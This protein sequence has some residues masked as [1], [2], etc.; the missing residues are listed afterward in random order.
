MRWNIE[1]Y[2]KLVKSNFDFQHVTG[3][4]EIE[5]K[6]QMLCINMICS[7]C[8]IM[9]TFM[10]EEKRKLN[11]DCLDE[12]II[13]TNETKIIRFLQNIFLEEIILNKK[14]LSVNEINKKLN[15]ILK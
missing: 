9:S 1:T 10:S 7:I 5:I 8:K 2:F 12:Y 3:K 15:L 4:E 14:Q 6:K 11:E 13:K